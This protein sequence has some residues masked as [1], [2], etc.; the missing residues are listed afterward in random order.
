M[1]RESGGRVGEP[2]IGQLEYCSMTPGGHG[3]GL[4]V[5]ATFYRDNQLVL[6]GAF[7]DAMNRSDKMCCLEHKRFDYSVHGV[8]HHGSAQGQ[9]HLVGDLHPVT[10][11]YL[12]NCMVGWHG[13]ALS[14]ACGSGPIGRCGNRVGRWVS[15]FG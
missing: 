15:E 4:R 13:K 14:I 1:S 11:L 8:V 2:Y 6:T 5:L 9:R 3:S 7:Q 12:K 10:E